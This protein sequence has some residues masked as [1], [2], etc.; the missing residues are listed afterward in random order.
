MSIGRNLEYLSSSVD[1]YLP[2]SHLSPLFFWSRLLQINLVILIIVLF[3]LFILFIL[4]E[5]SL[6]GALE[7]V[8]R[9]WENLVGNG[10]TQL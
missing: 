3:I 4:T 1:V 8:D 6:G 2:R 10:N 9:L 7:P 5:V